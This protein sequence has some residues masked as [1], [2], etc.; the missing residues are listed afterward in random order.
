M[1]L[2]LIKLAVRVEDL[3]ELR[4]IQ[5]QRLQTHGHAFHIT[6]AVPKRAEELLSGGSIYW[7]IKGLVTGRQPIL[8]IEDFL[9][10]EGV[11]RC[12]L[13]LDPNLVEV[14]RRP[15]KAFQG[16]RYLAGKDAPLDRIAG[17][18]EP[19]PEMAAE[20]RRLGLW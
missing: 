5:A 2:H 8:A 10:E 7:V 1:L 17:Q 15:C 13:V 3:D 9:D 12:R 11:R 6:R 19:P 20:L 14:E 16:W 4:R 18:E